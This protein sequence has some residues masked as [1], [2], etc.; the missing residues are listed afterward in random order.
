ME[1][2]PKMN[3]NALLAS[4]VP[5]GLFVAVFGFLFF[6]FRGVLT[7]TATPWQDMARLLVIFAIAGLSALGAR[8]LMTPLLRVS[9]PEVAAADPNIVLRSRIAPFV[10]ALGGTAIMVLTMTLILA[11]TNLATDDI[12]G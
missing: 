10:L 3:R 12:E 1:P 7:M 5:I 4:L 8:A 11:F 2:N 6:W 9:R